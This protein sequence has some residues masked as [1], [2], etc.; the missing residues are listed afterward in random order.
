MEVYNSPSK[1][2]TD[3]IYTSQDMAFLKLW[4]SH[5]FCIVVGKECPSQYK[6]HGKTI[7]N[8]VV[9]RESRDLLEGGTWIGLDEK[10]KIMK[11]HR[12]G[13]LL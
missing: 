7:I 9:L 12:K 5:T 4:F 6:M 13:W 11:M 8:A 1:F 2:Q 10:G 3:C